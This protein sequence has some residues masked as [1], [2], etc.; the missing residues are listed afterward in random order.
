ML[1]SW[2][3][4]LNV[5]MCRYNS[6]KQFNLQIETIRGI[7]FKKSVCFGG[8]DDHITMFILHLL[9]AVFSFS[10][11]LSC[12]VLAT[13]VIIIFAQFL[14]MYSFFQ[15]NKN[16]NLTVNVNGVLKLS[17]NSERARSSQI[18]NEGD[19]FACLVN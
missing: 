18:W 17:N 12:V 16:A 10:E 15:E 6:N 1:S 5:A 9:L 2:G 13:K 4:K 19:A 14:S 8:R 7:I 3:D 11:K